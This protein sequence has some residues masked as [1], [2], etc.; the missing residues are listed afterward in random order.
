MLVFFAHK[1]IPPEAV[2]EKTDLRAQLAAYWEALQDKP[3]M[4]LVGAFTLVQ[5]ID[6]MVLLL[7]SVYVKTGYGISE[8]LYGWIRTTNA[9]M[10]VLFQVVVTRVAMR[11]A[12]LKAMRWGM[13]FYIAGSLMIAFSEGFWGF[14]AA[15][16]VMTLGQLIVVPRASALA[17]NLAP[18]DK[19]G[20]YMSLYG[21]TWN[22]AAGISPV[23]G[24]LLSDRVGAR[25]PWVGGALIGLLAAGAF[26]WL[27]RRQS[28][29]R[30]SG[31]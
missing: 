14:W 4:G 24:A 18:V 21:L 13:L 28:R 1:T 26:W 16:V 2:G 9:L 20:R 11:Y 25:A 27:Q 22:A 30:E 12:A 3:F 6:S 23:L 29:P 5:M 10:V 15:M 19:R 17:A 7:F 31:F 8:S